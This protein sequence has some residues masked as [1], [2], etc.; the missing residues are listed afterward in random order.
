MTNEIEDNL[1]PLAG[2]LTTTQSTG[3]ATIDDVDQLLAQA[4][5]EASSNE[6]SGGVP[7]LSIKGSKF[8]MGDDLIG[9]S[10]LAV[11]VATAYDNA[12]YDRKYDP[13]R[14]EPVPPACFATNL[15]QADMEPHADSP[16]PVSENCKICEFNQ[17]KS[18]PNGKGKMCKNGR[19]LLL[20]SVNP[21]TGEVDLND[22]AIVRIPATS[23]QGWASYVK[24][25]DAI[26]KKPAWAVVTKLSFDEEAD[27][28]VILPTI[29]DHIHDKQMLVDIH[30]RLPMFNDIVVQPY[31]VE[32]YTPPTEDEAIGAPP[33]AASESSKAKRSKMS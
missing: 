4:A 30:S 26:E 25:L 23:L 15:V 3:I 9:K 13:D 28:P 11:V 1:P 33:S 27:W 32:G 19:R 10:L 29:H 8:R 17:F 2:E 18:A 21:Q 31:A 14:E 24:K 6:K 7:Y 16:V 22:L 20:A 12:Y 5:K